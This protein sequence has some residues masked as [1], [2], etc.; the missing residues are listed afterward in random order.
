MKRRNLQIGQQFPKML[1]EGLLV[2][3]FSRARVA[4]SRQVGGDHSIAF[5]DMGHD[6]APFEPCLR[7]AVQQHHNIARAT[8]H[9]MPSYRASLDRC[10]CKQSRERRIVQWRGRCGLRKSEPQHCK[11]Q[12]NA[13][14]TEP[15]A[16]DAHKA[17]LCGRMCDCSSDYGGCFQSEPERAIHVLLSR[18]L[19]SAVGLVIS[20][21]QN[22]QLGDVGHTGIEPRSAE[23][24]QSSDHLR[25]VAL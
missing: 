12:H 7:P 22:Q 14:S 4:E 1:G 20:V 10:S 18:G 2:I 11:E 8:G 3:R 17:S 15:T 21:V 9:I 24:S 16:S 25:V 5:G 23:G 13:M 19:T 6:I